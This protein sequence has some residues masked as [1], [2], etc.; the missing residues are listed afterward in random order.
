MPYFFTSPKDREKEPS[1]TEVNSPLSSS[2]KLTN[3]SP[4]NTVI[5]N[6]ITGKVLALSYELVDSS[7]AKGSYSTVQHVK[8]G[9]IDA[10]L[11]NVT[12]SE[13]E[14]YKLLSSP[15]DTPFL[16][17]LGIAQEDSSLLFLPK[18]SCTLDAFKPV[19]Q[20]YKKRENVIAHG[21]ALYFIFDFVVKMMGELRQRGIV[22]YDIKPKNIGYDQR[23]RKLYLFDFGTSLPVY[24][25]GDAPEKERGTPLYTWPPEYCGGKRNPPFALESWSIGTLLAYMNADEEVEKHPNFFQTLTERIQSYEA[26]RANIGTLSYEQ[27]EQYHEIDI[28]CAINRCDTILSVYN[29]M[30]NAL[31]HPDPERRPTYYSMEK[32]LK[33][34][35]LFGTPSSQDLDALYLESQNT[36]KCT[37]ASDCID[38]ISWTKRTAL[39]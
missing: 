38:D 19:V 27:L 32:A 17:P 14:I 16:K 35:K 30:S 2:V 6:F 3:L 8:I 12:E 33:R 22:H 25:P 34:M 28:D 26:N 23:E 37:R 18:L 29:L 31:K 7:Y 11:K 36:K 5:Q 39:T 9:D 1:C 24:N 4:K 21:N 13:M 10:I 15:L 20:S